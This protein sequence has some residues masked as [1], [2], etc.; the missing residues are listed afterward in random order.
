MNRFQ[1]VEREVRMAKDDRLRHFYTIGQT[2]TGKSTLLKNMVME[3]I[4]RGE[5]V[6]MIDPHGS[7]ILEVLANIPEER[8]DDVIY[9]D[10]ADVE[11][12]LGLNMLEYNKRRPEEKTFVV[13]ELFSIFQKLYGKVPES[14]GPMFEQYFRNSALLAIDN[15]DESATL[16]DISRILSNR[17]FRNYK[18]SKTSNPVLLQFWKEIAEKAGGEAALANIVPYITSKFDVFLAN[19]IMRPIVASE[20]SAFDMRDIMDS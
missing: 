12:P 2:G 8:M 18:L 15:R 4:R 17:E 19:D 6:C 1:G 14:M 13:N 7:D 16:L 11:R 3:D 20:K 10:P 9:F 5:G